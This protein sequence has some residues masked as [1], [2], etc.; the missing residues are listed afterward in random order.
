MPFAF[1]RGNII[2]SHDARGTCAYINLEKKPNELTAVDVFGT[3][4]VEKHKKML[5]LQNE[6]HEDNVRANLKKTKL[7]INKLVS[8]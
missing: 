4:E 7:K 6:D 1:W 2:L 3:L 8:K 5:S